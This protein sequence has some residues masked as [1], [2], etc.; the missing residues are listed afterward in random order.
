VKAKFKFGKATV[1]FLF[2][3]DKVGR[4]AAPILLF[5][6]KSYSECGDCSR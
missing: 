4:K 3:L 1:D 6:N 5:R 2:W